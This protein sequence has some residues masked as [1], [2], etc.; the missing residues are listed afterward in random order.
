[1]I[2]GRHSRGSKVNMGIK[3]NMLNVSMVSFWSTWD[4]VYLCQIPC[5]LGYYFQD[6]FQVFLSRGSWL[7]LDNPT[8]G[9]S[10]VQQQI[11]VRPLNWQKAKPLGWTFSRGRKKKKN[12]VLVVNSN[13]IL[14]FTSLTL[15]KGGPLSKSEYIVFS[16]FVA[17]RQSLRISLF[18]YRMA[19]K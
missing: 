17:F 6:L 16:T 15:L 5:S 7:L 18:F 14:G 10:V 8:F 12:R 11:V 13:I 9:S 1:M 4:V 3:L 2:L 19:V